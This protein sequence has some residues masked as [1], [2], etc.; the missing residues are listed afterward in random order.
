VVI[1]PIGGQGYLFGRGNQQLSPDVIRQVGK[2]N[3]IVVSTRHKI[4]S[5]GNRPFVVDTGD[6]ELNC[7]LS[8]YV[9][10]ITGLRR[11][12]VYKISH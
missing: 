4:N 7:A 2:E 9:R 3:I 10:V 11:Q 5:L 6:S 1:T 8:G 12:M